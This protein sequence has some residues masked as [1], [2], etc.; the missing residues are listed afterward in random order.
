M[1]VMSMHANTVET[2]EAVLMLCIVNRLNIFHNRIIAVYGDHLP[3][4]NREFSSRIK[5]TGLHNIHDTLI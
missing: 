5:L 4:S 2:L 3:S 1:N